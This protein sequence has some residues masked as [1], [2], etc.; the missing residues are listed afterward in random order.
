MIK[1][2]FKV[3]KFFIINVLTALIW[4]FVAT[5]IMMIT[6]YQTMRGIEKDLEKK[7]K[8]ELNKNKVV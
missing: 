5:P 1:R 7:K 2:L 3:V 4:I 8:D 6:S